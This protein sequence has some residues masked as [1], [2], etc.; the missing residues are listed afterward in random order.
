MKPQY[1]IPYIMLALLAC[2]TNSP[3]KPKGFE[4]LDTP[5]VAY[6]ELKNP[7]PVTQGSNF[8]RDTAVPL[9]KHGFS[10][11]MANQQAFV[12]SI[13][14]AQ[15]W[16]V[17]SSSK[18]NIVLQSD[19][20]Q[21]NLRYSLPGDLSIPVQAGQKIKLDYRKKYF[22]NSIGYTL[23]ELAG[24][25][26]LH[27]SAKLS[28]TKPISVNL[29]NGISISQTG[30]VLDEKS[31]DFGVLRQIQCVLSIYNRRVELRPGGVQDVEVPGGRLAVIVLSSVE[32]RPSAKSQPSS[33][34][35]G[36]TLEY[37]V[38]KR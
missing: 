31:S 33:E 28:D 18:N 4:N 5:R 17:V 38:V 19:R 2:N 32:N 23:S 9:G 26:L 8:A 13:G 34:G 1:Y 11:T 22:D 24:D 30:K 10:I 3:K 29:S 25:S 6:S 37:A 12:D 35:E 7:D 16:Q 15:T 20:G 14:F 21:L 27:A 36:F